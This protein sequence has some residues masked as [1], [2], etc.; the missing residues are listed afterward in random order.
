[1]ASQKQAKNCCF[2]LAEI[3]E[4]RRQPRYRLVDSRSLQGTYDDVQELEKDA[5]VVLPGYVQRLGPSNVKFIRQCN[6][7]RSQKQH[8]PPPHPPCNNTTILP[9]PTLASANPST[10]HQ[11]L[12]NQTRLASHDTGNFSVACVALANF[13]RRMRAAHTSGTYA[14]GCRVANLCP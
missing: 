3:T 14:H 7:Q 9:S 8:L 6:S 11:V 10:P 13:L 5:V 1:M 4:A 12:R 2:W